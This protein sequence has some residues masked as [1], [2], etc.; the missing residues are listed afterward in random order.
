MNEILAMPFTTIL[1]I[2]FIVVMSCKQSRSC[3]SH[4]KIL[5][6]FTNEESASRSWD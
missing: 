3:V 5:R 2:Y 6:V 1:R 4:L